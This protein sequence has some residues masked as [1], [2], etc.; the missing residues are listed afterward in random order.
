MSKVEAHLKVVEAVRKQFGR[1]AALLL[2]E[3]GSRSEVEEVIPTGIEVI[4]R[5]V[6]GCGG[7]PVGRMTEL[8]S[9]EGAGKTSILLAAAAGAQREG[10]VAIIAETENALQTERAGVFGV[11]LGKLVLLQPGHMEELLEQAESAI[12][13]V[14]KGSGPIMF[15]W[16]SIAATPTKREVD[17]GLAGD[18]AVGERARVLSRACRLL[19]SLAAQHRCALLFINQVRDNIG[20]MFG[21]KTTTPGGHAVKFAASVRIQLFSG[22][23]VKDR[24][25]HTG[26]DVTFLATKNKLAPPFR[27]ARVRI[28]YAKGWDSDWSTLE[29]AKDLELV[30]QA[31]RVG[32]KS[33]AEAREKLGWRHA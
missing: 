13:A 15:G 9:A 2:G 3:G 20:V 17:D 6:L 26:K 29:H 22:K 10:G 8:Y 25:G 18:A 11:D 27:K 24:E 33:M 12:T 23:A 14:P 4:D 16:D 7:L 5:Y 21:D 31:A 1:E 32:E 19:P 30:D 28:D